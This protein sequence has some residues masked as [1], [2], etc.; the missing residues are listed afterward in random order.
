MEILGLERIKQVFE[1][2]NV[3]YFWKWKGQSESYRDLKPVYFL[4]WYLFNAFC[5]L[6]LLFALI[7]GETLFFVVFFYPCQSTFNLN[8]P[9]KRLRSV[10][11]LEQVCTCP[12]KF[13][14]LFMRQSGA[15]WKFGSYFLHKRGFKMSLHKKH[16]V[17]IALN[18][19]KKK[20][21]VSVICFLSL[22]RRG[23]LKQGCDRMA[24]V[25][26]ECKL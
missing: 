14:L 5:L 26:N 12:T 20:K 1:T 4:C 11:K 15:T 8:E 10:W 22:N 3:F 7:L 19:P 21:S 24:E 17:K 9:N 2:V 18:P 25:M 13:D 23:K 16:R 6:L